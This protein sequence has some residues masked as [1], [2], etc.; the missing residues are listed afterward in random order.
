MLAFQAL[1]A[2][3][4]DHG[5][6]GLVVHVDGY[7]NL[8][9]DIRSEDVPEHASFLVDGRE[10]R[11]APTYAMSRGPCAIGGS[12]GFIEIALPNG[13]AAAALGIVPGAAVAVSF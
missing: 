8:I 9:T 4:T 3:G 10:L 6:E 1:R 13:S 11:L 7:G 2:P 12:S 5:L